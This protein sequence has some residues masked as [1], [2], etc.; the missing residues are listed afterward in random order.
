MGRNELV[1]RQIEFLEETLN[2]TEHEVAHLQNEYDIL[3]NQNDT[4]KTKANQNK[5][6]MTNI[7]KILL[8]ALE[9]VSK[10]TTE[11]LYEDAEYKINI[12][13]M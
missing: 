7:A 3:Y 12:K 5:A 11:D 13:D 1:R 8:Y 9:S 4:L 10:S 2:K 6:N